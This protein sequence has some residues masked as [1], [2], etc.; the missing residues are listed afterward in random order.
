MEFLVMALVADLLVTVEGPSTS[1]VVNVYLDQINIEDEINE[2]IKTPVEEKTLIIS[3]KRL[4]FK[5]TS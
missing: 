1:E 5:T 4:L 3:L 2:Q